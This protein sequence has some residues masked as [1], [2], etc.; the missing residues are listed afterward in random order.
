MLRHSVRSPHTLM[1]LVEEKTL[2]PTD[3]VYIHVGW[4]LSLISHAAEKEKKKI[5]LRIQILLRI[6]CTQKIPYTAFRMMLADMLTFTE[7]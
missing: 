2:K 1:W 3:P 6:H 5:L 4:E 7:H